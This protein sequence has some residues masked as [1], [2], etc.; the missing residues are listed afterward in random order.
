[1]ENLALPLPSRIHE[2][3]PANLAGGVPAAK[4]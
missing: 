2:A 1:M 4:A 3:V